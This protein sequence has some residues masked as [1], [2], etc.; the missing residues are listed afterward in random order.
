MFSLQTVIST[1]PAQCQAPEILLQTGLSQGQQGLKSATMAPEGGKSRLLPR[2][3]E[4]AAGSAVAKGQPGLL[5][6]QN[7][8]QIRC[9]TRSLKSTIA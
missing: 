9:V 4:C 1:G 7:E 3:G 6:P 5:A 2:T 8:K